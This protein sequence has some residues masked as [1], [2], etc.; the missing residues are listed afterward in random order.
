MLEPSRDDPAFP[1]LTAAQIERVRAFGTEQTVDAGDVLFSPADEAYDFIVVVDGE[2]EIS[3]RSKGREVAIIRHG[4][5]RFL[6][7]LNMLTRQRP[8]LTAR[9]RTAGR[10]VRVSPHDFRTMMAAESELSD[11]ILNAYVA[12]RN[13]HRAGEAVRCIPGLPGSA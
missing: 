7:E 1:T 5:G 11:F 3:N 10:V 6:G 2:V 12:R 13:V 9:V 8:M 4:P